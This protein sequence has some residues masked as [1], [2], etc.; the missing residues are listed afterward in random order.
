[1]AIAPMFKILIASH[2]TEAPNLLEALQQAGICQILNAEEAAVVRQTPDLAGQPIRPK[3]VEERL[4]KLG[5]SISFL[6]AYVEP[7]K[8]LSA[9][10]APR[11]VVGEEQYQNVV[12]DQSLLQTAQEALDIEVAM[13][14]TRSRIDVLKQ[15]LSELA[16]WKVLPVPVEEIS[17]LDKTE[18]IPGL[19]P[20]THYDELT[21]KLAE[22]GADAE[23][24]GAENSYK[25]TVVVCLKET[26][27]QVQK[28]L[29]S[30][31]FEAVTFSAMK[32]T[33]AEHIAECEQNLAKA[34]EE[35][36]NLDEKARVLAKLM[37]ELKILHDHYSNLHA[38]EQARAAAPATES[39][40][41]LEGWVK[42][43]HYDLLEKTVADFPAS[44]VQIVEPEEGEEPP[45]E[46]DNKDAVKPFESITRLYGMPMPSNLDPTVF[47]A[48]FFTIFFGLCLTDAGYGIFLVLALWYFIKKM[49]GDKKFFWM[50]MICSFATII[51]GALTGGWFGD[52]VQVFTGVD[53]GLN[54]LRESVV[55]FDPMDS[56][57]TFFALSLGLGY[58]QIMFGLAIALGHNIRRKDTVAAVFDQ[59]TWLVML[60]SLVL[61]G[62]AKAGI[63]LAPFAP[64][65]AVTSI[66]PA[67]MILL[68]SERQ[69]GWAGRIG[70]GVFSLF[71][72]VFYMG[73][74]LSY[75][76]I[77]ALGMVTA[78]FGMAVNICVGLVADVP[79]VGWLLG[80][81]VFVGGHLLNIGLSV[82][83]SFVHTMRLQFVEFFPKFFEGGGKQFSPLNTKYE[84][85]C[86]KKSQA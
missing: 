20:A 58:F 7:A 81:V 78:G 57:M 56:P 79:Y 84:H 10:L 35:L 63:I 19:L 13:E 6:G 36:R 83:G 32:G 64:L 59:V 39:A 60:N 54:S 44:S 28:L 8:G 1:M 2:R 40:L 52:A 18:V 50:L 26:A 27:D 43:R 73:D 21:E 46:I 76:R 49:Q 22:F 62:L 11:T 29:R 65:F 61:F 14:N 74:V 15:K 72:T 75:V 23:V 4:Y 30:L 34:Q 71:T 55:L 66:V 24:L 69:G 38:R 80:L 77:M 3:E 51:A 82:L 48:P 86:V 53:S 45:V 17:G 42:Q 33:V 67:I 41:I 70:M 25:V 31:E 68:G 16:P 37:L 85:I 47:L 5:R 9:A 12:E